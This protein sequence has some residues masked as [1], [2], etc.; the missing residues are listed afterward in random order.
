MTPER[1]IAILREKLALATHA[2]DYLE[3]LRRS[4]Q[5]RESLQASQA[6]LDF[7]NDLG[8]HANAFCAHYADLATMKAVRKELLKGRNDRIAQMGD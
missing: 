3:A 8:R 2:V 4:Y 6:L 1:R 7:T 5:P